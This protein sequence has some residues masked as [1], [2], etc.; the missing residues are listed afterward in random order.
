M[1]SVREPCNVGDHELVASTTAEGIAARRLALAFLKAELLAHPASRL[2]LG[3]TPP[4]GVQ[5]LRRG[6]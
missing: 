5:P 1:E 3:R 4:A 6:N 2:V